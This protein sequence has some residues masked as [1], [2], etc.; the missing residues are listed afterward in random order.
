MTVTGREMGWYER[1]ARATAAGD[2]RVASGNGELACDSAIF[3]ADADS[4]IAWG[5]PRVRDSSGTASGDTMLFVVRD[6][7]LDRVATWGGAA[8]TYTGEGG[9]VVSVEGR[10]I[11]LW[12]ERGDITRIEVEGMT[13]GELRRRTA[14]PE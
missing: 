6:G 7:A 10:C 1:T 5:G 3:F 4:G 11:R 14:R 2:V 12:I 13:S 8:G 9:D